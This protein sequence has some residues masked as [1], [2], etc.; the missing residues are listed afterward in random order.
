MAG[1]VNTEVV[2]QFRMP[3]YP[4]VLITTDLLK[5]GEDLH[6]FCS[7]V[8][9]YGIAWMPSELEQRVGRVDRL[10]SQTARRLAARATDPSGPDKLQVFYPHLSDTVE[11]LQLKRVY[12]R[13]NKFLRMMHQGLGIPP[14]ERADI[15]VRA[16]GLA[17]HRDIETISEPLKTAFPVA[18]SM[19][20]GKRRALAMTTSEAR[21]FA[22]L[23]SRVQAALEGLEA[24]FLELRA[25][26]QLIG[27]LRL[28]SRIQPF[29]LMLRSIQGQPMLRCVSPVGR[30]HEAV[31][32]ADE[33]ARLP[34][35]PFARIAVERNPR[36][37]SYD[38]AIEGDIL[39]G[40]ER[41]LSARSRLLVATV[42]AAA[43][44]IERA[45]FHADA[46]LHAM[47]GGLEAEVQVER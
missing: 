34:L 32:D 3:G 40:S 38:I 15:D 16:E 19:L 37:E 42:C 25:N 11:V 17:V 24:G 1:A 22:H 20:V 18:P 35:P 44:D 7:D 21:V 46:V 39:L 30:L 8:Y 26:N 2:R 45:L 28:G 33:I 10:G 36:Y 27:Q 4:L 6:T 47:K 9:H 41:A 43:D 13:L 31:L 29:T 12:H 23:M 14:Q 5:E